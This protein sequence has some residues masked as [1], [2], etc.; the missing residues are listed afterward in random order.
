ML[1]LTSR[2]LATVLAALRY[3]QADIQ[4]PSFQFGDHFADERPLSAVEIDDLCEKL[5]S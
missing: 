4:D 5:N 2:E 3:W 1:D